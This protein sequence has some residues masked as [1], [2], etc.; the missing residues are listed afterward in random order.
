MRSGDACFPRPP[1]TFAS[2][3]P[4][5]D[6]SSR[7]SEGFRPEGQVSRPCAPLALVPSAIPVPVRVCAGTEPHSQSAPPAVIG[8]RL[9]VEAAVERH[10]SLGSWRLP[11]FESHADRRLFQRVR[12]V[13]LLLKALPAEVS[14]LIL[15]PR[16]LVQVP[17]K[18]ERFSLTVTALELKAGPEG[19]NAKKGLRAWNLLAERVQKL[20]LPDGG[21]P[22]GEALVASII[23]DESRRALARQ[24]GSR[25]G[26]T[27]GSVIADGFRFLAE[28]CRLPIEGVDSALV[29][30]VAAP[31]A[32]IPASR[33]HAGSLPLVIQLQLEHLAMS[34]ARSVCRSLA[35]SFLIS[36][37]I[38][39]IRMND[40]LNARIWLEGDVI[41][42]I[43]SVRS[44]DGIPMEL[45]APSEGWLGPLS[46]VADHL[47]S[48]PT[49]LHVWPDFICPR[50][51]SMSPSAAT[52]FTQ[53]VMP[54]AKALPALRELCSLAP[55]RMSPEE[56]SEC[57]LTLHSP[58][59]SGSDM[60]RFLGSTSS[61]VELGEE[62]IFREE[63]ARAIGHWLRD[64]SAPREAV[65]PGGSDPRRPGAPNERGSMSRRYSQGGGRRGERQEQLDLRWRLI[66]HVRHALRRYGR[67]WWSLPRSLE[68]WDILRP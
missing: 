18:E 62:L 33:R 23:R 25:G 32:L 68:S 57:G 53:G 41:L 39:H 56:F 52:G 36:T 51:L 22:A 65:P 15:G 4:Q 12:A 28:S 50:G 58:H 1:S 38:H 55:L 21:L 67:P 43:T 59:G 20:G 7:V 29:R 27:V 11:A 5:R 60:I 35:R 66:S 6:S 48:M 8:G 17:D 61:F 30:A 10:L 14:A 16:A 24:K 13:R 37:F 47:E 31:T 44:K 45:F 3:A 19:E 64:R 54:K 49:S 26:D 42:G 34:P 40:A 9:A 2:L 63:D 46:W